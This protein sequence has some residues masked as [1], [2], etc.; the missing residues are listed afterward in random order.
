M[1]YNLLK[2]IITFYKKYSLLRRLT[3]RIYHLFPIVSIHFG[4]K[5]GRNTQQGGMTVMFKDI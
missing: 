2:L 4:E 1:P 3:T 5:I